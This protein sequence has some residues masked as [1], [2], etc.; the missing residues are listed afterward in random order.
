MVEKEKKLY[1]ANVAKEEQNNV[2]RKKIA[3]LEESISQNSQD[4]D[5]IDV[6]QLRRE[7]K[8]GYFSTKNNAHNVLLL[9]LLGSK[10]LLFFLRLLLQ[11]GRS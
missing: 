11:E 2:L 7:L 5:G 1:Y 8:D 9:T 3:D 10:G 4:T 6:P